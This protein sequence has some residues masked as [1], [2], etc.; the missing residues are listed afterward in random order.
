MW[1]TI[2]VVQIYCQIMDGAFWKY[3]DENDNRN[4]DIFNF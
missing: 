2:S 3:E 4:N 1:I